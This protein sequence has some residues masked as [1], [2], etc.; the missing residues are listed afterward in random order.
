MSISMAAV[1]PR[2]TRKTKPFARTRDGMLEIQI[3]HSKVLGVRADEA[4]SGRDRVSH[5]DAQ[6]LIGEGSILHRHLQQRATIRIHRG[7]PQLRGHHLPEPLEPLDGYLAAAYCFGHVVDGAT[8]VVRGR[9]EHLADRRLLARFVVAVHLLSGASGALRDFVQRRLRDVNVAL[10][11]ELSLVAK[12]K[13]EQEHADVRPVD[14][15]VGHDHDPTVPQRI[16]VELGSL[17]AQPESGD[18]PLQ[19]VVLVDLFRRDALDVQD[20]APQGQYRLSAPV[21]SL[22]GAAGGRVTLDDEDLRF[23]RIA[24]GAV[25]QLSGQYGRCQEGLPSHHV[26]SGASCRCSRLRGTGFVVNGIQ[27]VGSE[28]EK[29]DQLRS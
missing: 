12:E 27:Q 2:K 19:L 20:L 16:D 28:F 25:G 21:S 24:R 17:H 8:V 29:L 10:L 3:G 15:G 6:R 18:E 11:D 4:L 22:L 9:S 14:V 1:S 23:G 7:A 5:Q 26:S 13:R